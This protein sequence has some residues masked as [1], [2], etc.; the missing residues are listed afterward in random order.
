MPEFIQWSIHWRTY[1]PVVS[2]LLGL[3]LEC[4][5][6]EQVLY[7]RIMNP[8]KLAMALKSDS[9]H[10]DS[11]STVVCGLDLQYWWLRASCILMS[12]FQEN[13]ILV[14]NNFFLC[15]KFK[16][17]VQTHYCKELSFW[18]LSTT[19]SYY[20]VTWSTYPQNDNCRS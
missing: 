2:S 8:N 3:R 1:S 15:W 17:L 20:S 11:K 6:G 9:L 4:S 5:L 19:C 13:K 10:L 18:S 7:I 14:I 12:W 16:A